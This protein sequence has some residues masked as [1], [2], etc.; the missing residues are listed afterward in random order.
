[1]DLR[2][3]FDPDTLAFDLALDGPDLAS[4]DGLDTAVL[5]SLFADRR[6]EPDDALPDAAAPGAADFAPDRRGWWADAFAD[7]GPGADLAGS[8]LWLLG[9]SK[10]AADVPGLAQLYAEEGLAWL[11]ADGV[12]ASV[13]ASAEAQPDGRLALQVTIRRPAAP[14]AQ[15]RFD[16]FWRRQ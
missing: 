4:D 9:R 13:A 10:L 15:Y 6:A 11:V 14:P 1:M 8:R 2:L 5:L 12:A 7:A 3:T 16:D